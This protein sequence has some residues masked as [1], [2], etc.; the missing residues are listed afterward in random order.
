MKGYR[1][2]LVGLAALFVV[3]LLLE[4]LGTKPLDWSPSY[5]REA[6]SPFGGAV[7]FE[8]VEAWAG[9]V[10]VVDEPPYLFLQGE[11]EAEGATYVFATENFVTDDAEARRLLAFAEAG[12]TVLIAADQFEGPLAD[13]LGLLVAGSGYY[14]SPFG[15]NVGGERRL[16]PVQPGLVRDSGHVLAERLPTAPIEVADTA[17]AEVLAVLDSGRPALVRVP[18]GAGAFVVS[19]TPGVFT[20]YGLLDGEG[21]AFTDAVLGGLAPGTVY[22]D[23]HHKP[24]RNRA[25][26][27]LRFVLSRSEL[28]FAYYLALLLG[29]LFL[30]FRG[31][32]WQRPVPLLAEP[33]N[34]LVGFA[35]T[36]GRLR[37]QQG[38]GGRLVT[39]KARYLR[40]RL[41]H[42]LGVTVPDLSPESADLVARRTG[43]DVDRVHRLFAALERYGTAR[44]VPDHILIQLDRRVQLFLRDAQR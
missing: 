42:R 26:T 35:R 6:S 7:F 21:L 27:P 10:E 19:S 30:L 8:A 14:R 39:R 11:P 13:A 4:G 3:V 36:L 2:A 41:R 43:V 12:G 18:R 33:P 9:E 23:A 44:T 32:R 20:N 22:W 29:L 16:Y 31:K 34:A 5:E 1:L 25:A 40:D 17:R 28:R 38:E 24:Q 37:H 15:Y